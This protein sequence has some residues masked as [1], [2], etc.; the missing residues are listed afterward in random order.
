MIQSPGCASGAENHE[1]WGT[2]GSTADGS[3]DSES[4][5]STST[6]LLCVELGILVDAAGSGVLVNAAKLEV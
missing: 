1:G 6:I 5:P 2:A 3:K 4:T